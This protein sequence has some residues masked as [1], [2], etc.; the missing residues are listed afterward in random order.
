MV[1]VNWT[2]NALE[3]LANIAEYNALKSPRYAEVIVEKLLFATDILLKFPEIGRIVPEFGHPSI[4][5]IIHTPYRIVYK[6]ISST[7]I[8]VITVHHASRPLDL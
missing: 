7:Q 3:D 1:K 8:D 6:I 5:E 2:F 4:R